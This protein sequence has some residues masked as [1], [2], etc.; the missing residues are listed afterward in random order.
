MLAHVVA[1]IVKTRVDESLD[2][3]CIEAT[4]AAR[5]MSEAEHRTASNHRIA[6]PRESRT[7][8]FRELAILTLGRERENPIDQLH[9][10]ITLERSL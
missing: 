3:M 6:M 2:T 1:S 5:Q 7:T 8:I 9:R 10:I 4:K